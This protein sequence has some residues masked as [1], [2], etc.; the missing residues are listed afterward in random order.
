MRLVAYGNASDPV[1]VLNNGS[2]CSE[3][4]LVEISESLARDF[5]VLVAVSDGNDGGHEPYIS[6]RHQAQKILADLADRGVTRVALL[7]GVSMGAEI[8]LEILRQVEADEGAGAGIKVDRA[9]FDGGPFLHLN[10]LMRAIMLK[11]FRGMMG[12]MSKKPIEASVASF[13]DSKMV[14]RMVGDA[15][16]GYESM[17]RDAWQTAQTINDE[18][19]RGQV[20]TCYTCELPP[21]SEERQ[22]RMLFQ[23]CEKEKARDAEPRVCKAYP[24]AEFRI[25]PDLGHAGLAA[26]HPDRY[27]DE[28]RALAKGSA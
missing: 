14:V 7:Q 9:F 11:K 19:I 23:W 18:Q 22:R 12:R 28:I 21:F 3:R 8:A 26:L 27:A 17:L 20:T 5:C 6:T 13:R 15:A 4:G 16:D 10:A 25:I 2:F 24:H 1:V